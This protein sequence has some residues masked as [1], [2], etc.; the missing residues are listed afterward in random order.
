MYAVCVF[1]FS[2]HTTT[3][4][5]SSRV[6]L[7][8][9]DAVVV[10]RNFIPPRYAGGRKRFQSNLGRGPATS[11]LLNS[12]GRR[13]R[14]ACNDSEVDGQHAM[15]AKSTTQLK[16]P[17]DD[18]RS[19]SQC[20]TAELMSR[21]TGSYRLL[22]TTTATAE[23][24]PQPDSVPQ[25]QQ[26]TPA[27]TSAPYTTRE[28]LPAR[29]D[30]KR[31][32]RRKRRADT[33]GPRS[34]G[35]RA[36]RRANAFGRTRRREKRE[37]STAGPPHEAECE[38]ERAGSAGELRA[39]PSRGCTSPPATQEVFRVFRVRELAGRSGSASETPP[40]NPPRRSKEVGVAHRHN[41]RQQGK[42]YRPAT[43]EGTGNAAGC[44]ADLTSTTS[45]PAPPPQKTRP[46]N[47]DA[48]RHQYVGAWEGVAPV[49]RC[50][51]QTAARKGKEGK[52]AFRPKAYW[53][54]SR[55]GPA[56]RH[57]ST[58]SAWGG[59]GACP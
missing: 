7:T 16:R 42:R 53:L 29:T 28:E 44:K 33:P 51:R 27:R 25:Q 23:R 21:L 54:S 38:A 1:A 11:I 2:L 18:S 56:S 6:L 43:N 26:G 50:V 22:S 14:P 32:S 41:S 5:R 13:R 19:H 37:T 46:R 59:Y 40:L 36:R 35:D 47:R 20:L 57:L 52:G 34:Q 48:Q 55:G 49:C 9:L 15:T 3:I 17:I 39:P 30:W 10:K 4:V 12:A 31:D 8:E 58:L 24:L 45:L